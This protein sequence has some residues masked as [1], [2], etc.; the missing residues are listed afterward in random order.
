MIDGSRITPVNDKVETIKNFLQS[1]TLRQLSGF[2]GMVNYYRQFIPN[3]SQ[4]FMPLTNL[5]RNQR[6][7]NSIIVLDNGELL[8][9]NNAKEALIN[10]I[11]LLY[12]AEDENVKFAL[13]TDASSDTI[14]GSCYTKNTW[15]VNK[16]CYFSL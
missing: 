5:L 15:D 1:T 13:T 3:C 2:I 8:A 9:F 4:I 14:K 6:K 16:L 7:K 10:Y 12:R 11:K